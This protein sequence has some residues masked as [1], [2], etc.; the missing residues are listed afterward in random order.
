MAEV[1]RRTALIVLAL[2][3]CSEV[4]LAQFASARGECGWAEL[5]QRPVS[6]GAIC[7]VVCG[8]EPG[9]G[10]SSCIA[11]GPS[12]DGLLEPFNQPHPTT[13]LDSLA[14]SLVGE[15]IT[16][17]HLARHLE[18]ASGWNVLTDSSLCDVLLAPGEWRAS[19]AGLERHVLPTVTGEMLVLSLNQRSRTFTL[20]IEH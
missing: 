20:E 17:A 16:V 12:S 13:A 6:G 3:A 9:L 7:I 10:S 15:N 5:S 2:F 8:R 4:A 18:S 1:A 19:G 14:V 11:A